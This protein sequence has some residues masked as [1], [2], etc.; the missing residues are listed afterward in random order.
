M[1]LRNVTSIHDINP[2]DFIY[3]WGLKSRIVLHKETSSSISC[4]NVCNTHT[5]SE[6]IT[7]IS[8]P[9][10]REIYGVHTHSGSIIA[11]SIPPY[12]DLFQERI[13]SYHPWKH[14]KTVG[15]AG[16]YICGI[17]PHLT[18]DVQ[19]RMP[20]VF[21]CL[22]HFQWSIFFSMTDWWLKSMQLWLGL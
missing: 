1:M 17:D 9:F 3:F 16:R 20:N 13:L 21:N 5:C 22:M 12:S 7:G 2:G 6:L 18:V 19:S 11:R 10:T 8:Y 14:S 15:V 4:L